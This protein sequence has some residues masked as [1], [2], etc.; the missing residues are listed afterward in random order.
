MS[1]RFTR[2]T[3]IAGTALAIALAGFVAFEF[4]INSLKDEVRKTL[5]AHG[6][7]QEIRV[8]LT[9]IEVIG[10]R[11]RAS[12]EPRAS[13]EAWPAEDELR[14]QRVII[15]P[16]LLNLLR[17]RIGVSSI[18]VE[19][20]YLSILRARDGRVMLLPSLL[21]KTAAAPA[22]DTPAAAP[23]TMA[24]TEVSVARTILDNATIEFFDAT[25]AKPAFKV[26]LEQIN[27]TVGKL[28]FPSLQGITS[29]K[30]DGIVKGVRRDGSLSISGSIELA[31]RE[32]GLTGRLAAVDLLAFQPYLMKATE[33]GVKSGTLD[34]DLKSSVR[35]NQLRAPGVVTLSDLEFAHGA[36]LSTATG[37]ARDAALAMMKNRE[38]KITV[39]FVVEGDL[40]DPRFSLNDALLASLAASFKQMRGVNVDALA[41][42]VAGIR[43]GKS[44]DWGETLGRLFGR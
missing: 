2:W 43:S 30:V 31:T 9:A 39:R 32:S 33:N 28:R 15:V 10:L 14:A 12:R 35:D 11:I 23:A 29:I 19:G 34:F 27:A 40:A 4:A 1:R 5:G 7:V 3:L 8:G 18:R 22:A 6:E 36:G 42:E 44:R 37:V 25:V 41:K 24:P 17:A 20:A 38:G 16:D 26:R 21:D 13:G